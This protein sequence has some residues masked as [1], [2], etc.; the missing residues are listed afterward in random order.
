[1]PE[2][3]RR[4]K[5]GYRGPRRMTAASVL[6]FLPLAA[7]LAG[8]AGFVWLVRA[9][10]QRGLRERRVLLAGMIAGAL[11][12]LYVGLVWA[13]VL[14]DAYLRLARPWV[15]ALALAA[16][17]FIAF[18]LAGRRTAAGKWRVRFGDLLTMAAALGAAL[19]AA[20]PEIGR[21]LDRLTV[22]VAVDRSRS[23][24]LV[25]GA[26]RRVEVAGALPQQLQAVALD[27]AGRVLPLLG[28]GG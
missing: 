28:Q 11:P 9:G 15:A 12:A 16:T 18:R 23:I 4:E 8:V 20:G 1:M 13:R 14:G 17:S 26:P 2:I 5:V 24:D 25:P 22:L 3:A 21:P 7:L 6:R 19:A 27:H 10:L